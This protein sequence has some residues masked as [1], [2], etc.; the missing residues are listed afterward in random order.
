MKEILEKVKDVAREAGAEIMKFY[1]EDNEI[2]KKKDKTLVTE[3]DLLSEKIILEGLKEFNYGFLSE[4]KLGSAGRAESERVWV[5]DPIDGTMDFIKE[6][7]EFSVMIGLVENGKPILGVVY[8]PTKDKLYSAVIGGGSFLEEKG[9]IKKLEVSKIDDYSQACVFGGRKYIKGLEAKLCNDL[10]ISD[11][12]NH[13]SAGLKVG[14]IA[15]QKAD[16]YISSIDKTGEW[17]ICAGDIILREAGGKTTD[18]NGNDFI[19]NK[20]QYLNLDGFVASNGI[21]HEKV[22]EEIKKIRG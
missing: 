4:E 8:Q 20:K 7:G 14:L 3:V 13:G 19:Y 6:T 11:F 22:I 17:D 18:M 5:I 16:L 12:L 15:E 2:S 9:E 10:G 21:L 1:G